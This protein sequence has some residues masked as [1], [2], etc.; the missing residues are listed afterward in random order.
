LTTRLSYFVKI[1]VSA[2]PMCSQNDRVAVEHPAGIRTDWDSES[3]CVTPSPTAQTA[4]VP[5]WA[6]SLTCW[7]TIPGVAG[8]AEGAWA[9][10]PREY[11]DAIEEIPAAEVDWPHPLKNAR[12]VI[13]GRPPDVPIQ[14]CG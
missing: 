4:Q 11:S 7:P 12:S 6:G 13:C 2:M 10:A 9:L 14:I 8:A 1:V 3:V 5:E